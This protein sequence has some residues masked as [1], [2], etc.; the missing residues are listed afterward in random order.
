MRAMFMAH[1]EFVSG[2]SDERIVEMLIGT[3][4]DGLATRR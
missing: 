4:F 1:I 2:V 3:C